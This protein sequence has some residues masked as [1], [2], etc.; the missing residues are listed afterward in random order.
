MEKLDGRKN[1]SFQGIV[2]RNGKIIWKYEPHCWYFHLNLKYL[3]CPYRAY[4][5]TA[6]NGAFCEELLSGSDFEVVLATFCCCD[7]GAKASEAV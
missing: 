6:K 1:Q 5:R 3:G 7:H 4:I 2:I